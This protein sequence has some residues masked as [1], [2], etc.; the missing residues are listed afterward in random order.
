M[1]GTWYFEAA[2]SSKEELHQ[3]KESRPTLGFSIRKISIARGISPVTSCL[4]T[5][6][7]IK[8]C[9]S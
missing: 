3:L 8:A 7:L 9:Q 2:W 6:L 1:I 5:A 4:E